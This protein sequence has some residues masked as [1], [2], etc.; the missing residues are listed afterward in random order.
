MADIRKHQFRIGHNVLYTVM[1]SLTVLTLVSGLC[2]ERSAAAQDGD[3][4]FK[5]KGYQGCAFCH[6]NDTGVRRRLDPDRS[7]SAMNEAIVFEHDKHVA[8]FE[9][10][11]TPL[12]QR[13]EKMLQTSEAWAGRKVIE[14]QE[15]LSCHSGWIKGESKPEV[16][17]FG[18]TC[19]ACHGA[20]SEW[21]AP[22]YDT[23]WRVVSPDVKEKTY[24]FIDV[25]NPVRRA[26]QCFSCHIGNAKEGKVVTHE[27]Y[28][29]GHPPLPGIEIENFIAEMPTHWRGL[30]EKG[31]FRY[32]P[33]Y[34]K[35]N[36]PD[37]EYDPMQDLTKTKSVI[38]G[39][40][41]AL[42]ESIELLAEQSSD[43]SWPELAVFDCTAC[44]H[45]LRSPAWRQSRGYSGLIP[46]RP[47]AFEWPNALI[48]LAINH[49][50]GGDSAKFQSEWDAY[51]SRKQE[52]TNA[53]NSQPFGNSK[54]LSAAADSI[55][56][57]LRE[58]A[59]DVSTS[60]VQQSH[61]EMAIKQLLSLGPQDYPDYHSAR[62]ILWAY[63]TIRSEVSTPYPKL[64]PSPQGEESLKFGVDRGY[65]N[66]QTFMAWKKGPQAAG[67]QRVDEL[68]KK[69]EVSEPMRLQLPSTVD[70][71]ITAALPANLE[72]ISTYDPDWFREKLK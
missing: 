28:A 43:P 40:V 35:A 38:V 18:V 4:R 30:R 67:R 10:L 23:E 57:W 71:E 42:H 58:L 33:G 49:R 41:M 68:L 5:Y 55:L 60:P 54:G 64:K 51:T 52:L 61:A 2:G 12:G 59:N 72:G 47:G 56:P 8:A 29:A 9:L 16:Y 14:A 37:A 69:L 32:L 44:H 24:N 65:A 36:Y 31:E 53:L 7:F 19:E 25:R 3:V 50:A 48:K 63:R 46:G 21:E 39:G 70:E 20:A 66:L 62:Q 11:A 22:H 13:M 45:D 34:L 27:M 17:E 6:S 1:L 15:C 26:E